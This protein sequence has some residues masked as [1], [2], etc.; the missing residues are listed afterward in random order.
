MQ[1]KSKIKT[2]LYKISA[3]V[4]FYPDECLSSKFLLCTEFFDSTVGT[5]HLEPAMWVARKLL[6]AV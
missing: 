2:F 4:T 3:N 5:S 6:N 1:Q